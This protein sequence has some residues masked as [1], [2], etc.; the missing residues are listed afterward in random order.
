MSPTLRAMSSD[1]AW[2]TG[3]APGRAPLRS[4][5]SPAPGDRRRLHRT[6]S[7]KEEPVSGPAERPTAENPRLAHLAR[8]VTDGSCAVLSFDIFDTVVWRRV[9]RPTDVFPILAARLKR[10]GLCPEWLPEAAF[11]RM[12][13]DAERDARRHRAA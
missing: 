1:L 9:P 11:R 5:P 10:D 8:M 6:R 2:P 7:C 12:R 4:H 13:I 3:A